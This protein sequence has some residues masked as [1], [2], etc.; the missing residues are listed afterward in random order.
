MNYL[1][2]AAESLLG[3]LDQKG[4]KSC[5][6]G[7]LANLRW[8][9]PRQTNDVDLSVATGWDR[10]EELADLLLSQYRLRLGDRNLALRTRVLLLS[11][12]EDVPLDVALG[13]IPFELNCIGRSSPWRVQD[14][15]RLR[16]CS[17]EDLIVHKVFAGRD[18][19]WSDVGGVIRRQ[20]AQLDLELI[21]R[22]LPPLLELKEAMGNLDRFERMVVDSRKPFRHLGPDPAEENT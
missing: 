5:I 13:A 22:E 16:T 1:Y 9:E 11:N 10:E 6:I 2:A 17:A 14:K 20:G 15:Y 3:L 7:G 4:W 8:G 21:R 12:R 18:R 19:D